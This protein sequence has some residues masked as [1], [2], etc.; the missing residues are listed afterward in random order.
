M[1]FNQFSS[2]FLIEIAMMIRHYLFH[3]C[4]W[5]AIHTLSLFKKKKRKWLCLHTILQPDHL[6]IHMALF[7]HLKLASITPETY[8]VIRLISLTTSVWQCGCHLNFSQVSHSKDRDK[9]FPSHQQKLAF[10]E[11]DMDE[12]YVIAALTSFGCV[13][14]RLRLRMPIILL[15]WEVLRG[16]LLKY[17]SLVLA[18]KSLGRAQREIKNFSG[19]LQRNKKG[20]TPFSEG[21][22]TN[23]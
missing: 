18:R 14:H 12:V 9:K 11:H 2:E 22:F 23:K 15:S 1:E 5:Y 7:S 19:W 8:C 3:N 10:S 13:L 17:C 20:N 21:K 6:F 4:R 16:W